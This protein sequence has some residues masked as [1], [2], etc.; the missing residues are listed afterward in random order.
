MKISE[1][2]VMILLDIAKA[3]LSIKNSLPYSQEVRGEVVDAIVNQQDENLKEISKLT[4][5]K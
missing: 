5:K 4:N 2:Q 1:K 3:S